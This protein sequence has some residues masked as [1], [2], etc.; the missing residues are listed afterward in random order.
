[1]GVPARL[2]QMLKPT[3]RTSFPLVANAFC[4]AASADPRV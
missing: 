1:V 2:P 4:G 3:N